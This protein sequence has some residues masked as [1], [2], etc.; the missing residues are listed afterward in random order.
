MKAY[1]YRNNG[2]YIG[3]YNCQIDPVR[4]VKEGKTVYLLPASATFVSPPNYDIMVEIPV[5]NGE[6][7]VVQELVNESNK[8]DPEPAPDLPPTTEDRVAALEAENKTLKAQV[9]AQSEQMDFYEDCIAEMATVV[10][11]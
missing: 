1:S 6:T 4:S 11:A 3:E 8:T 10:Y 9:S 5:W 7:W 2:R